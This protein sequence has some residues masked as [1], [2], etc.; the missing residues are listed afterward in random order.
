MCIYE[1]DSE[2]Y[3]IKKQEME[4]ESR[5]WETEERWRGFVCKRSDAAQCAGDDSAGSVYSHQSLSYLHP[6]LHPSSLSLIIWSMIIYH[7]SPQ[8]MTNLWLISLP[9][10]LPFFH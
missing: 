9:F 5:R 8:I 6:P 3:F 2:K 10:H 1:Q 7:T 4:V